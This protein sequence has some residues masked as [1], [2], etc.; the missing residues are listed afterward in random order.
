MEQIKCFLELSLCD[1]Q[2]PIKI[3][4]DGSVHIIH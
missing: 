2:N 4:K 1:G 3:S